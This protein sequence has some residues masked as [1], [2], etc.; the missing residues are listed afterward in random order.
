[1]LYLHYLD[2]WLVLDYKKSKLKVW[3][4]IR[5]GF[6][7]VWMIHVLSWYEDTE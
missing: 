3:K 2:L 4:L 5:L 6:S 7:L 1:M